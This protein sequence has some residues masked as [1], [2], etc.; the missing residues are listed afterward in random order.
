M[1]DIPVLLD[2]TAGILTEIEI[3]PKNYFQTGPH[4]LVLFTI[5]SPLP[6]DNGLEGDVKAFENSY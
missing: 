1:F 6:L 3:T 4:P 5:F 2:W